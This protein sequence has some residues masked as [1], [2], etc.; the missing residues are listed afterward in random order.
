M[1]VQEQLVR[2]SDGT[3]LATDV[4]RAADERPRP[5]LLVQT[6]YGRAGLRQGLDPVSLVRSGWA[7]VLQDI[8]GRWDSGGSY[9]PWHHDAADGADVIAWCRDQPWSDGSVVMQ[10]ASY[11]GITAWLAASTLPPGLAAISPVVSSADVYDPMI[12]S[13]GTLNLGFLA[14]WGL[15]HVTVGDPGTS[16]EVAGRAADLLASWE[17]TVERA[18]V[19]EQIAAC[20][21]PAQEWFGI[22]RGDERRTWVEPLE[23]TPLQRDGLPAFHLTGWFDTF[24][25]GALRAYSV[26][27]ATPA[28]GAQRLVVGPWAHASVFATSCGDLEFGPR[29]SGWDRFPGE[30]QEFLRRAAAGQDTGGG[31]TIW[32]IGAQD[33]AELDH[34]PPPTS[35]TSLY[36]DLAGRRTAQWRREPVDSAGRLEWEHDPARPVPTTGGRI[37][38]PDPPHGPGPRDRGTLHARDDVAVVTSPALDADLL[39]MGEPE[40]DLTLTSS[41][42][43][44]DLHVQ[45]VQ[46][47][48]DGRAVGLV[49]RAHR[50]ALTPHEPT[51]VR[52]GLG[53]IAALIPAGH[54]IAVELASSNF[55]AHDVLPEAGSRR[56]DVAAGRQLRLTL[57]LWDG[58]AGR[59]APA[60][61]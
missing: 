51:R 25:E 2:I 56:V 55:P 14:N 41:T 44:T 54:E 33:W 36:A 47:T 42:A 23:G 1:L 20:F 18:D 29:A 49:G 19:V 17:R 28:G 3:L 31:A 52:V 59:A 16:A 38:H 5:V 53:T 6:P 45:L 13:G 43:L 35:A 46:R 57:P 7:V 50:L 40:L 48:P 21:P 30:Q 8:R 32:V 10:G 11:D 34:W 24:V 39:I 22:W 15:G 26:L 60:T 4:F 58:R 61:P 37:L 12:T 27:R 9:R